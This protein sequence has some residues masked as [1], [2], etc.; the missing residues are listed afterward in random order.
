MIVKQIT[1]G[2]KPIE[3]LHSSRWPDITDCLTPLNVF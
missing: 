2:S 3:Q 1:E